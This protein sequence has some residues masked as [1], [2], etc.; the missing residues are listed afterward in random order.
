MVYISVDDL[1]VEFR[2]RRTLSPS[3]LLLLL[4]LPLRPNPIQM[5]PMD[6]PKGFERQ[7]PVLVFVFAKAVVQPPGKVFR[8]H[9]RAEIDFLF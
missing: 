5:L 4:L 9:P 7:L 3:L 1:L 8:I 6:N 2:H